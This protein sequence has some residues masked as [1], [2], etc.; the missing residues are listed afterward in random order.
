MKYQMKDQPQIPIEDR[1]FDAID[2]GLMLATAIV[3]PHWPF[4]LL[5]GAQ[6][7]ARRSPRVSAYILDALGWQPDEAPAWL[8]P[9]ATRLLPAR[10]GSAAAA[11]QAQPAGDTLADV[12]GGSGTA[13]T[14]P[15]GT[16]LA[17]ALKRLPRLVELRR[18]RV[19][20]DVMSVP[21]G[22][23]TDGNP[24]WASLQ[25]DVY[26]AG[27]Y[28]TSGAGKDALMRAWFITLCKRNSP[29]DIRFAIID[30]KGDWLVPQLA[31][32]V[33]MFIVPAG[34][35][36]KAGDDRIL[37]AVRMIDEEAQDR[38]QRITAAGCTSRDQ[39][40]KKTGET[41]PIL[42]VVASDVMTTVAGDVEELLNN[43]VSKARSLG[44]RVIVSM[45]TPTGKSTRW[46]MNLST[47]MAG[48]LQAGS[49]DEPAM[50][51]SPKELRYRPSQLPPPQKGRP[52][53][54]GLFVT[55]TMGAELLVKA[56]YISEEDFDQLVSTL[57]TKG[58]RAVPDPVP[59]V[60]PEPVPAP[61]PAKDADMGDF[62][63]FGALLAESV[64]EPA[65]EPVL[66]PAQQDAE[67]A[68]VLSD[69]AIV[70]LLRGGY[71]ANKI[72]EMMGGNRQAALKRI[73]AIRKGMGND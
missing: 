11:P 66:V 26:H 51:V 16:A 14:A 39:F 52:E 44:I 9:G 29:D 48:C 38:Q 7:V 47:V 59:A 31:T 46:R 68:D 60:V 72:A 70:R 21:L 43:L 71:S 19:P 64:P 5:L 62:D 4:G 27:V 35:Y 18:M 10:K 23:S 61:V 53:T 13:G 33:H 49:Q 50:G 67:N 28:G 1:P 25:G 34:G 24:V 45:Q 15:A 6:W 20:A 12:F 54:L 36:G 41:M 73:G 57:P 58:R 56:P 30:G 40:V 2:F 32:L 17:D 69:G 42:V 37:D 22:V 55:R 65:A 63:L 8:L 3:P